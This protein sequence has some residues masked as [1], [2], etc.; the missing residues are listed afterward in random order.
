MYDLIWAVRR[1]LPR[2]DLGVFLSEAQT[3]SGT[4]LE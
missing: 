3:E 1:I 4:E 2:I